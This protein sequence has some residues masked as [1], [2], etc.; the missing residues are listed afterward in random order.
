MAYQRLPRECRNDDDYFKILIPQ[1]QNQAMGKEE[2][3]QNNIYIDNNGWEVLLR[4]SF[5]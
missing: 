4:M 3:S 2:Q 5:T 1:N